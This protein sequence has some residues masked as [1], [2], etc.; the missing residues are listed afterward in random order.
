M[1]RL[2]ADHRATMAAGYLGY[3]T[4]AVINNFAPLLFVT[5]HREL[6]L[7]LARLAFISAYNFFVQLVTD[8]ASAGAIRRFGMRRSM[9]AADALAAAGLVLLGV[10]PNARHPMAGL[11]AASTCSAV[12]GGLMEVLVSP[13][14]E[15]CPT[16][17][18]SG[19]M[20]LLHSFYCWGQAGTI[21]AATGYFALF[22]VARWR[23]LACLFALVPLADLVLFTFVPVYTLPGDAARKKPREIIGNRLFFVLFLMMVGAGATEIAV[24]QWASAFAERTL[25]VTKSL[26]DLLGPCLFALFMGLARSLHSAVSRR[27]RLETF[28][29]VS[30]CGC[31]AGYALIALFPQAAVSFAG[32]ALV[33]LSVGILW[34]GTFSVAAARFPGAD[35]TLFALL[36]FAGDCGCT[37]GPF[38]AGRV[39][40]FCGDDLRRGIAAAMIFPLMTIC[41]TLALGRGRREKAARARY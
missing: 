41:A 1:S 19:S 32:F 15:A 39:A 36:A 30:A 17:N 35:T 4:Q 14:I 20:S 8:L 31:L 24:S 21:L 18:K 34:P 11:I 3:V 23:I 2:R 10:L 40:A 25:G 7:S 5:F 13:L 9:L 12:G 28:I 29:L 16:R 22:G 6:G 27:V 26:G 38:T 37:L 33:G